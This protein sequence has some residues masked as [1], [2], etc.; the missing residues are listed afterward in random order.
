MR[1]IPFLLLLSF[2]ATA[3]TKHTYSK[4]DS[5][6]AETHMDSSWHYRL[7]A[8]SHQRFI[9][10]ALAIIPTNA[11]YW[12]QK[13][14]PLY[15][16]GRYELGRPFL[17]SAVKYNPEHWLEYK[18]VMEC[19]FEKNYKDALRDLF[20]AKSTYGN[21][22]VMDHSYNF[23]IGLCY[24]QLNQLDSSEQYISW[25]IDNDIKSLGEKWV[26]PNHFFYMGIIYFEREL[27]PQ[28]IEYLKRCVASYPNFSDAQYFWAVCESLLGN[29]KE[30]LPLM[31]AANTNFNLGFTFNEDNSMY[32]DYPYQVRRYY[33]STM[34]EY[35]RKNQ[36]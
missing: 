36:N 9:D 22:V 7:G 3:Q 28:A 35:L 34:L 21:R 13:S 10:S 18:A 1:Y 5:L 6:R 31:E 4:Q 19:I 27:Y 20:S 26:H 25:C 14:M 2:C 24:L 11:W 23:Y 17:D 15:K 32:V 8:A 16:S 30:A 29:N 12:Q 33:I